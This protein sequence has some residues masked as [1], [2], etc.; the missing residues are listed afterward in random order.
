M[1]RFKFFV[2]CLAA[3]GPHQGSVADAPLPDTPRLV[4]EL[5][6]DG[7][8]AVDRLQ[9]M[10]TASG[11]P[12]GLEHL[13]R[14]A[15][16][17]ASPVLTAP[18]RRLVVN[19]LP[20]RVALDTI[21]KLDPRYAWYDENGRI[22]VRPASRE[23]PGPLDRRIPRFTLAAA[24]LQHAVESVARAANASRPPGGVATISAGTEGKAGGGIGSLADAVLEPT[25]T[26]TLVD[27]RVSEIVS[28]IASA[29]GSASWVVRYATPGRVDGGMSLS[30]LTA[31]HAV[32]ALSVAEMR[33]PRAGPSSRVL[34]PFGD[35]R[36]ALR[37]YRSQV[38]VNVGF[39]SLPAGAARSVTVSGVPP[40]D[41][42][43][44]GAPEAIRRI[45][46]MDSRYEAVEGGVVSGVRPRTDL[47][48]R[49]VLDAPVSEFREHDEPLDAIL[50]RI[51]D[52][53]GAPGATRD[54]DWRTMAPQASDAITRARARRYS[55]KMRS[56]TVR[57]LLDVLCTQEGTLSWIAEQDSD[58]RVGRVAIQSW[59]GWALIAV[60]RDRMP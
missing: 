15:G 8:G 19:G 34:V 5:P 39:E 25:I 3:F 21:V 42:T 46:A 52:L 17:E 6:I 10:L 49:S 43:G 56:T 20:L 22:V 36:Q 37:I 14:P 47:A 29:H 57:E 38:H 33:A 23:G 55:L 32:T 54:F 18:S 30:I 51:F 13:P 45:A 2:L 26:I 60:L 11:V 7:N 40:L 24:S 1:R 12:F 48:G 44:V 41:L 53:I 59:D 28:A 50:R 31:A 35:L 9:Q 58:G 27:Q 16:G 4:I